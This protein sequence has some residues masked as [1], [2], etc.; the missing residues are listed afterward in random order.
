MAY[1]HRK[2][3]NKIKSY[4][5]KIVTKTMGCISIRKNHSYT[6]PCSE[7]EVSLKLAFAGR[8]MMM[9]KRPGKKAF[10]EQSGH[11]LPKFHRKESSPPLI[12]SNKI[13]NYKKKHEI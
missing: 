9:T 6:L 5:L 11:F 13:H 3:C 10:C 1:V 2:V 7:T 4:I 8:K 12:H